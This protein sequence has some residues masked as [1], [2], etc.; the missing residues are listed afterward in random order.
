MTATHQLVID[1]AALLSAVG[2]V[3][4]TPP[5]RLTIPAASIEAAESAE[6]YLLALGVECTAGVGTAGAVLLLGT[7]TDALVWPA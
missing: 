3:G 2:A 7:R 4:D 6:A 5:R 1:T